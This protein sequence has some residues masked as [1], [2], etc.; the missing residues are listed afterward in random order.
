L[1]PPLLL[2]SLLALSGCHASAPTA[3]PEEA[4]GPNWFEDVTDAVGLRASHD[5]PPSQTYFMPQNM[6]PGGAFLH[7]ADGS[8]YVYLL[9]LDGPQGKKNQLFKRLT[10]GTFRDVSAGSGLDLAGYSTGVAVGDVNND[11]K[12]DVLVTQYG[13]LRLFL[14]LGGGRFEDITAESGLSNPVW[15]MSAAFFDYDRDG[16]LDLVVVNYLDYDV[17]LDCYSAARTRDFCH[18]SMFPGRSS[19]LFRNRGPRTADGGKAARASFE[20]VSFA[21]GIGRLEGPGLGVVCADFTGDGWPDV[22]VANDGKP[23]RLWVNQKDGTFKDEATS[24][25]VALT[26][27]GNAYAGMGVALGDVANR[28]LFDLYVTHLGS[29]THTLWRQAPRGQF[30]D[31]TVTSGLADSRWR[32]TGFGT[33]IADFDLDG[34]LDLAI[35]NGR[36]RDG[37]PATGTDLGFWQT[38]AERNQIFA[39]DGSGKFRDLSAANKPFCGYWN[40]G[41]GLACTDFD[42]DGAPD[43][44]VTAA[45]G[46]ARLFRNVAPNRGHWLKVRAFDPKR[47]R[48]AYGAEVRVRGGGRTWLRLVNPAESYLSSG[49]PV[50][51]F[52]LGKVARV[53]SIEVTWPDGTPPQVEVF[54]GGAADRPIELRRGEGRKP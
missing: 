37:G 26:A 5:A 46:R 1:L 19:K 43:L 7:D 42:G 10:N 36:V 16:W 29:E 8:L 50:A 35:V 9:H 13:G 30:R 3:G 53:E 15:G 38:Y 54:D 34:A 51:H 32:G 25:G 41:R 24:R 52:G 4:G 45:G 31:V 18:P 39:N 12:P 44:L 48:D 33:V 22:F 28:G 11:G 6:A 47:R 17:K 23:N 2:A 49:A 20:D 14:N 21:S 27:M 40:V